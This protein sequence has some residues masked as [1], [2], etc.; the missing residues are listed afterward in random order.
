MTFVALALVAALAVAVVVFG[1]LL[2]S[3]R[4]AAARERDLLLNQLLHAVDKPWQTAPADEREPPQPW[5]PTQTR[6]AANIER[7]PTSYE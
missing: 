3:E 5:E 1:Q 7:F 6:F 4:R 2:R